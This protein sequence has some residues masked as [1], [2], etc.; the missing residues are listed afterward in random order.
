MLSHRM[1]LA[2]PLAGALLAWQQADNTERNK[3][4]RDGRTMTA[5]KQG[6]SKFDVDLLARLRKAVVDD[7]ELSTNAH[8]VKI[9]V[10]GGRIWLRGPV[11]SEAEK[12]RVEALVKEIAG[13]KTV[14][15]SLEV[16]KGDK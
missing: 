3:R 1:F 14:T 6:N 10:N 12:T 11:A 9:V 4:D 15:S 13:G 2:L 7:K 5:E 16:V 8:N